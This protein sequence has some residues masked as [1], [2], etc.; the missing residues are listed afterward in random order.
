L[1]LVAALETCLNQSCIPIK[2]RRQRVEYSFLLEA[3]NE[4]P[5]V[6]RERKETKKPTVLDAD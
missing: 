6:R 5:K 1:L 4:V 3:I 2:N